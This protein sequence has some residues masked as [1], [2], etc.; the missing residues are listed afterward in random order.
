VP[1]FAVCS[2]A[3]LVGIDFHQRRFA[4]LVRRGGMNVQLAEQPS[5]GKMLLWRNAL[6]AEKDDDVLG[7]RT[8]DF[9]HHPVRQRL[10]Q[11]DA[12]DLRPDDRRELVDADRLVRLGLIRDVPIARAGLAA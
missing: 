11:V 5:K 4:R 3:V 6:L 12:I 2:G 1:A 9:I 8:M 10:R 7:Q